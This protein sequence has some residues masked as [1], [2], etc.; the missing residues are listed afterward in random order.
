MSRLPSVPLRSLDMGGIFINYRRNDE[1]KLF[2]HKVHDRLVSR[3]GKRNVFLDFQSIPP[4]KRYPNELRA[5]LERA[6]I[7]VVVLHEGWAQGL[8]RK[9]DWVLDEI[10]WSL[11]AGKTIIPVALGDAPMPK[12]DDLPREIREFA[13][14]QGHRVR[15]GNED[16]FDENDVDALI[17]KVVNEMGRSAS[18]GQTPR[19]PWV[20]WLSVGVAAVAFAAPVVLL[21]AD[22]RELAIYASL[23]ALVFPVS[24]AI[25]LLL[26]ALIRKPLN[27]AERMTQ[28]FDPTRYYLLVAVP[29]G[30]VLVAFCVALVFSSP[31]DPVMRP[32]LVVI[33]GLGALY[34][35]FLLMG[36]YKRER[37]REENWPVRV[38]EPVKAAP[39]RRELERLGRK[40]A[41]TGDMTRV[42]WH[43]RHL[44]NAA[45]ALMR[46]AS[47]GRWGWL[48]ADHPAM[49]LV[50]AAWTPAAVGLMTSAALPSMKLW[51]PG[52]VLAFA[53]VCTVVTVEAG[54]RRQRWVRKEV[55]GEVR[56][57]A[58]R[59]QDRSP[60]PSV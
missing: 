2:V 22:T 18:V 46:D 11:E 45:D 26:V 5:H 48:T 17:E 50:C 54:F 36:V 47:R 28:D 31:V 14:F 4:G 34:A 38:P 16:G 9:G 33:A 55:A 8:R 60:E 29:A 15:A 40:L 39:V 19:R 6:N 24:L 56:A 58:L 20:G 42:R 49:L 1:R 41:S 51:I 10:R 21:P 25:A 53:A 35:V 59:I 37:F 52:L 43:I 3:V 27:T 44:E 7:V 30:I 23:Y 13:N 12:H 57:H 32:L